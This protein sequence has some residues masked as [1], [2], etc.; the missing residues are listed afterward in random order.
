MNYGGVSKTDQLLH[1]FKAVCFLGGRCV[2]GE[3]SIQVKPNVKPVIHACSKETASVSLSENV[4]KELSKDNK[5]SRR[6]N[7]S[8]ELLFFNMILVP[9]SN[10]EVRVCLDPRYPNPD[11]MLCI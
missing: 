3:Y 2:S 1:K 7:R 9:K 4:K 6:A 11:A 8:A 5:Q 10:G